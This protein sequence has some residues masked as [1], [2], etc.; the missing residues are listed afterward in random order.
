MKIFISEHDRQN[1]YRAAILNIAKLYDIKYPDFKSNFELYDELRHLDCELWIPLNDYIRAYDRWFE[2]YQTIKT[3]QNKMENKT[4]SEYH[5]T[6]AEE[7]ELI[8]L[9]NEREEKLDSLQQL[10]NKLRTK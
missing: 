6:P 9:I 2:F 8:G 4:I 5:L 7:Q 1:A 10:Y 3:V